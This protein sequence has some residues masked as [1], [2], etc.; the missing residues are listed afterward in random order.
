MRHLQHCP[1]VDG[2]PQLLKHC[3][4]QHA[5]VPELPHLQHQRVALAHRQLHRHV[6]QQSLQDHD[7]LLLALLL[8]RTERGRADTA[9]AAARPRCHRRQ[10][11]RALALLLLH[12]GLGRAAARQGQ[13]HC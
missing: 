5:A 12:A 13:P 2:K 8:L 1:V 6:L 7:G 10:A 3:L 11:G 9:A 4:L